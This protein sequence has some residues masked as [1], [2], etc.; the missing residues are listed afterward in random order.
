MFA[1]VP[2]IP[3]HVGLFKLL[4]ASAPGRRSKGTAMWKSAADAGRQLP[5]A[6]LT[7]FPGFPKK[8]RSVAAQAV[9]DTLQVVL[10]S[11]DYEALFEEAILCSR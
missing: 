4:E 10:S 2:T 1:N 8:T 9:L 11:A 3:G 6:P 7:A 5:F